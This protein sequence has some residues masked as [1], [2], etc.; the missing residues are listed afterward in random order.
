[1]SITF[2]GYER[3]ID[4]I[5]AAL[6]EAGIKDLEEARQICS[7]QALLFSHSFPCSPKR[8]GAPRQP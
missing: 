4:K 2:E 7:G 8:K 3:R 1:M 6:K 5:N